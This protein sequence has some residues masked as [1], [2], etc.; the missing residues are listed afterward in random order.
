MQSLLIQCRKNINLKIKFHIEIFNINI[1]K[2][3]NEMLMMCSFPVL[4]L[5]KAP[6]PSSIFFWFGS[7]WKL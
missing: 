4:F 3:M 5:I 1:K 6:G 7:P 2:P